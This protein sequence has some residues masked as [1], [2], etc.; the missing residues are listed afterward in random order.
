MRR[1]LL[2][3]VTVVLC[4]SAVGVAQAG[5]FHFSI[6][7]THDCCSS[8]CSKFAGCWSCL[9]GWGMHDYDPCGCH[10]PGEYK[11]PVPPY[12]TYHWPG[13]YAGTVVADYTPLR[14]EPLSLPPQPPDVNPIKYQVRESFRRSLERLRNPDD[15]QEVAPREPIPGPFPQSPTPRQ[16]ELQPDPAS[17][18][19]PPPQSRASSTQR[20][21]APGY[22]WTESM[23]SQWVPGNRV[24]AGR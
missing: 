13:R 18:P 16:F 24:P 12:Y 1:M 19:L 10:W 11:W 6:G 22:R 9:H 8:F 23:P 21:Y 2:P 3:L 20:Q 4:L 15:V 5:D 17:V 14:F 7:C